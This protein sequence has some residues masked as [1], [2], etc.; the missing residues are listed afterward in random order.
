M[1]EK[2]K[3]NEHSK[4]HMKDLKPK[5]AHCKWLRVHKRK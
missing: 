2:E 4:K 1:V 3:K 5:L